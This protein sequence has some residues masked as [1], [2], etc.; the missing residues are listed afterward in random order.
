M[1]GEVDAMTHLERGHY[2]EKHPAGRSPDP[3]IAEAV[4]QQSARGELSCAAA[5]KLARNLDVEPAEVGFAMDSLELQI[6]KCQMGLF[7]YSPEK[8]IVKPA[9]S[10]SESLIAEIRKSLLDARLPCVR[11]WKIAKRRGVSKMEVASACESL[12]IK[13]SACQLGAF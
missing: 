12:K 11:A 5:F 10:V 2:S 9:K 3:T 8:R 7:G 1:D 4:R 6:V 13:I